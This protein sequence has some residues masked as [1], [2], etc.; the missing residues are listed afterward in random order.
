MSGFFYEK[1]IE[2]LNV[3][4]GRILLVSSDIV[5]LAFHALSRG[6]T[7]RCDAFIESLQERLTPEGTLLFP[8][9]NFDFCRGKPFDIRSSASTTGALSK[10]ALGRADFKRTQH[11][12]HSFAVWGKYQQYLCGLNN[13]SSFGADSP[14]AFLLKERAA[15]LM[16]GLS[17]QGAFTF[18]HHA[19]EME[20][21]PY[22]YLKEF[23]APYVDETGN[24]KIC[25]YSMYVRDLEKGVES[26]L[27]PIGE[28][29]ETK[30]IAVSRTLHGVVFRTVRLKEAY[31]EIVRDIRRNDG[32]KLHRARAL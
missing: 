3:R 22:R 9:F 16:I 18:A 32:R 13:K 29:L 2:A 27:D 6:E 28:V 11:P 10:A 30:E 20:R 25:G 26:D 1:I 5:G 24:S 19:E 15:A 14:F 17:Y 21:V 12:I 7:F 4:E 23:I 31:E 8:T